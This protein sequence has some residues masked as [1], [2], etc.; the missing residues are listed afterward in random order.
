MHFNRLLLALFEISFKKNYHCILLL[1][2]Q[3]SNKKHRNAYVHVHESENANTSILKKK[4]KGYL[5][6]GTG[7]CRL[8]QVSLLFLF[9][10]IFDRTA[11][12]LSLFELDF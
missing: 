6:L 4:I 11:V 2:A 3:L 12:Y 10:F 1:K 9:T 5:V 8:F 7:E